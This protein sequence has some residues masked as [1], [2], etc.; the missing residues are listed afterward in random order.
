MV[1]IMA[2]GISRLGSLSQILRDLIDLADIQH[3]RASM[4]LTR[5]DV[6]QIIHRAVEEVAPP[7]ALYSTSFQ[8]NLEGVAPLL[9]VDAARVRRA[10]MQIL[11]YCQRTAT[12]AEVVLINGRTVNG[13]Y[14]ISI[15]PRRLARSEGARPRVQAVREEAAESLERRGRYLSLLIAQGYIAAS[16]GQLRLDAS[17][18]GLR[19][20]TCTLPLAP[21]GEAQQEAK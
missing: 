19:S 12:L 3:G 14:E 21:A 5:V 7:A 4:T 18:A 17:Q 10:L 15:Q 11:G 20:V 2:R 8:I 13:S 1:S 9:N 6:R 16:G